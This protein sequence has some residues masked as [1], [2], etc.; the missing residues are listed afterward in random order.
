MPDTLRRLGDRVNWWL[1]L[2]GNANLVY[3]VLVGG[4]LATVLTTVVAYTVN[5]LDF[6]SGIPLFFRAVFF[7][8]VFLLS[9]ALVNHGRQ[10][11]PGWLAR[12]RGASDEELKRQ[13]RQLSEEIYEF[14]GDRERDDPHQR[15][16]LE[17]AHARKRATTAEEDRKALD[18]YR[19]Q[20]RRYGDETR[21]RYRQ[22]FEARVE[23]LVDQ[24]EARGL[25]DGDDRWILRGPGHTENY[26]P[27]VAKRLGAI[28]RRP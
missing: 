1:G 9:F 6:V 14:F 11:L 5:F 27:Y 25:C 7:A 15:L 24:L 4:A 21:I 22:R 12:Q 20:L 26:I 18:E 3:T 2:A 13:C 28:G 8:S 17:Y 19:I 10:R 16:S 23:S